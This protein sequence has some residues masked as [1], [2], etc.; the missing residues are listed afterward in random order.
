VVRCM[1][2]RAIEILE[3]RCLLLNRPHASSM[4]TVVVVEPLVALFLWA[5]YTQ[6]RY[7]KRSNRTRHPVAYD[8]LHAQ[9]FL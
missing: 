4:S 1:S 5:A 8:I 7:R 9:P 6:P 3:D 2:L